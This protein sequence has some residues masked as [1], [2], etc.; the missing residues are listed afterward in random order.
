MD[1]D[2]RA[3]AWGWMWLERLRLDIRH[4][5]R[6]W[7]RTPGFSLIAII[8][9]ALGIGASTAIVGQID[10]VFWRQLP[11]SRP[12][13]LRFITWTSPRP[14]FVSGPNALTGPRIGDTQTYAGMS[15][16][17][18]TALRDGSRMFSHVACWSDISEA[19]PVVI[20]ES[21]FGTIHFVS[22]NYFD[23]LG[24]RAAVGRTLV[25]SDDPLGV[26]PAVAMISHPFWTRAYG[27]DPQVTERTLLLN[28]RSFAIVGVM[29]EGFF[30]LDP[31]TTPDV[32]L[33]MNAVP[34]AAA[35]ANA[36]M[37]PEFWTVCRVVGRLAED[38]TDEAARQE[39][40]QLI[41]DAIARQ[42]PKQPYDPPRIW[43]IDG[44]H[45]LTTLRDATSAPL[46]VLFIV[47]T[48]LLLAACANIAGLLLARGSARQREIATRLAL[49]AP[50]ARV[51]RQLMTESLVLS[52]AGGIVAVGVAY[53]LSGVAPRL[54]SQFMPLANGADRIVSVSVRLDSRVFALSLAIALMS[55]LIF[56]ALPAVRGSRVSLLASIRQSPASGAGRRRFTAGH[57][58]VAA[59]TALAMLLLVGAGM[60]LRTLSNLREIDVGFTTD[61]LLYARLEPRSG[62]IPATGRRQFFEN[63]VKRLESLPGV[64]SA[65]AS[66]S[67]P[68]GTSATTGLR[69]DAWRLCEP[70]EA[71]STVNVVEMNWV[72]PR[73]FETLG[74]PFIA[75]RDMTWRDS[76]EA[77]GDK[78]RVIINE[79]FARQHI[80]R[81]DALGQI[82]RIGAPCEQLQVPV[83][84]I[85]VVANSRT[86]SRFAAEPAVY[87]PLAGFGGPVTLTVRTALSAS[88][89]VPTIR[90]AVSELH[91]NVSTFGEITVDE[92]R[93]RQLR[94]ERLL[95]AL[96]LGFGTITLLVCGL[97]IYGLLSYAVARGRSEISVRMA[98]GAGVPHIVRMIVADS[99][100]PIGV[101]TI[102]GVLGAVA[103]SR[104]AHRLLFD[105][106]SLDPLAIAGAAIALLVSAAAAAA[107]PARAAA[108]ID[109]VLALRQ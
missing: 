46:L 87:W 79:A 29:P 64:L 42:P 100:V 2:D 73:F 11:V 3:L 37:R 81:R 70:N 13:E 9:I 28:G 17:A 66:S 6:L 4:A 36:L 72:A 10:A 63:A 25:A 15:Y 90:R 88:Q 16:P 49:G 60:F 44:S 54:L 77:A 24:V 71:R 14:Q 69:A 76:F 40:G 50:R 94:Q 95:S 30:G 84:I 8:T 85:G 98:I 59:Q 19:R 41:A 7:A 18:Y 86:Q 97:G 75:G 93:E 103:M 104:W 5:I 53:A 99:L 47:I 38:A 82:V 32:V 62:G 107:I 20:G 65:S 22:G 57:A 92:L 102:A 61:A 106:S 101:G 48:G 89:L 74:V 52:C 67:P 96:L 12:A 1:D 68:M 55:G 58:M 56:G 23:T 34:I 45:G 78:P 108:R 26:L 31:S 35:T 21:G 105:V 80:D 109:P 39:T 43:L 27:R 33:P 91:A 83:E 51:I